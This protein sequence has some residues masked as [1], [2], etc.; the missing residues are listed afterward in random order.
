MC[1]VMMSFRPTV[2]RTAGPAWVWT[3]RP[4]S[5]VH[6]RHAR[7]VWC[8]DKSYV[9]DGCRVVHNEVF[10]SPRKRLTGPIAHHRTH[11]GHGPMDYGPP[12][13]WNGPPGPRPPFPRQRPPF[14]PMGGPFPPGEWRGMRCPCF[15]V[16]CCGV[17]GC[18]LPCM[19]G[20]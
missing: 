6:G 17:G 2:L 10:C 11:L 20:T 3:S 9:Q 7:Y 13:P 16:G 15:A 14:P 5:A 19:D 8:R 18:G 1:F 4:S 12:G